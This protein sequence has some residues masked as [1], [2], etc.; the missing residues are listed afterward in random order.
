MR[1]I[2]CTVV[3]MGP[4]LLLVVVGTTSTTAAAVAKKKNEL[5]VKN[6]QQQPG[7][8]KKKGHRCTI[9][10]TMFNPK[11][12]EGDFVDIDFGP[13]RQYTC[14]SEGRGRTSASGSS[15]SASCT[16]SVSS[17]NAT[18]D[19]ETGV[20]LFGSNSNGE[21]STVVVVGDVNIVTR[22]KNSRGED[23]IFG[24]TNVGGEICDISPDA[25]GTNIIVE[26]N[27]ETM[28]PP[29]ADAVVESGTTL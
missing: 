18:F 16:V 8:T 5:R 27:P 7:G 17:S 23:N 6:C 9:D 24:S 2:S 11:F 28:Y 4:L 10:R 29:E 25:T 13:G 15:S 19:G 14:H 20:G 3:L 26:C 22:G 12:V 1:R 21:N